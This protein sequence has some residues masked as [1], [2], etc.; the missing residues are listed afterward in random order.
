MEVMS[1]HDAPDTLHF[2]DPPY[3]PK[4]RA[5]RSSSRYYRHEMTAEQHQEPGI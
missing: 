3:L 4:T 5:I 2:V 1:Q